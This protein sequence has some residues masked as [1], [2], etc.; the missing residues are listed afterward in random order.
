MFIHQ[1]SCKARSTDPGS[2]NNML[3]IM[4]HFTWKNAVWHAEKQEAERS[5]HKNAEGQTGQRGNRT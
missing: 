4:S 5:S 1:K 3:N 2:E